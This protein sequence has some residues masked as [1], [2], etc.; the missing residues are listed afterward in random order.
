MP[1]KG[2]KLERE[3][4]DNVAALQSHSDM[5]NGKFIFEV[6]DENEKKPRLYLHA[7][8]TQYNCILNG[9]TMMMS[10][11]SASISVGISDASLRARCGLP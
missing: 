4:L 7:V 11:S 5:F 6:I 3:T 2:S 8:I 10:S 9:L 1:K